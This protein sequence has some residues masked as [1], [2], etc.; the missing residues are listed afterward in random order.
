MYTPST[1]SKTVA[2]DPTT[3]TSPSTGSSGTAT[4][5]TRT[6]V[7]LPSGW[8]PKKTITGDY[9]ITTAGAVVEDLKITDGTIYVKANNV[10]LRRVQG[11][12]AFVK[13]DPGN[14]CS[15]GLVIEDSEF[16][17][18]GKTS[19]QDPPVI[20]DGGY[21]IRRS[22]VDNRPEGLRAGWHRHRLRCGHR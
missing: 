20:G 21:T 8:T 4:F 10:T 14:S 9:T 2:P 15:S 22:V 17:K 1:S 19:D 5:P 3:S 6:S 13:T 7:G 11:V 16:T 12:G 18:N